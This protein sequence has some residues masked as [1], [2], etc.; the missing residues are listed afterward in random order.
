LH[1]SYRKALRCLAEIQVIGLRGGFE[2]FQQKAA[3]MTTNQKKTKKSPSTLPI[4]AIIAVICALA[5]YWLGSRPSSMPAKNNSAIASAPAA[6]SA[7]NSIAPATAENAQQ[8]KVKS[9]TLS[10][11]AQSSIEGLEDSG[12]LLFDPEK[13]PRAFKTQDFRNLSGIPSGFTVNNLELSEEGLRLPPP[14]PGEENSPRMGTIESPVDMFEFPS[15]AVSP[16]WLEKLPE[17][18]D[19]FV[20]VSVSANGTDWGMWHWIEPDEHGTGAISEFFPDGSPNPNYGYIPGSQLA[21][22]LT[23]WAYVRY[24]VTLYAD[25]GVEDTPLLSSFRLYYQ[26]STL[27]EGHL[28]EKTEQAEPGSPLS[29]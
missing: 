15:N 23:Q 6:P 24:R 21:W 12:G 28:A 3:L 9:K 1:Q 16:I 25:A 26:D 14:N 11:D 7:Q 8:P 17:G 18:T 20:E 2:T 4:I 27:G 5:V 29:K 10:P 19:I 22:G 13:Q